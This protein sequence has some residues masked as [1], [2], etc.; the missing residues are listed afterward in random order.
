MYIY[1]V[2]ESVLGRRSNKHQDTGRWWTIMDI[3]YFFTFL[4]DLYAVRGLV[5]YY[6]CVNNSPL[7]Q[8]VI[9]LQENS[10][11]RHI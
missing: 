8:F 6:M 4:H 1:W 3:C 5:I 10:T 2:S 7:N 9:I 11:Y